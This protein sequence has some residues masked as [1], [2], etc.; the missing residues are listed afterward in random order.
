MFKHLELKPVPF[1]FMGLMGAGRGFKVENGE[2]P[3]LPTFYRDLEPLALDTDKD[4]TLK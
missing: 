2:T 1:D 4:L 3:D